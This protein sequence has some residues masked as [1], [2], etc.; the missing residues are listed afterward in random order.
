MFAAVV[1]VMG[2]AAVVM[3]W[4]WFIVNIIVAGGCH[5]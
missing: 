3:G 4:V 1:D 5:G 2:L